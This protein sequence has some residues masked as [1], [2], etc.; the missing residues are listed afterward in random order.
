MGDR[1]ETQIRRTNALLTVLAVV[2]AGFMLLA[3]RAVLLPLAIA[4]FLSYL[5]MPVM[6]AGRKARLPV[7]VL[8]LMVILMFGLGIGAVGLIFYTSTD[9]FIQRLPEYEDRLIEIGNRI[10]KL[11]EL[12][13]YVEKVEQGETAEERQARMVREAES[14]GEEAPPPPVD[15]EG[16]EAPPQESEPES[17][18]LERYISWKKVLQSGGLVNVAGEV[19]GG[20]GNALLVLVFLIFILMDRGRGTL[21]GRITQAFSREGTD[22]ARAPLM[23]IHGEI[24]KYIVTKTLLSLLTGG[25]VAF[26]LALLDIPFALLF[27]L[28][29][30]TLNYIPNVG[31]IIASV[32]PLL[33]AGVHFESVG[34]VVQ[35]GLLLLMI[36]GSIGVL[37]PL[38]T[39]K[40]L[41]LNPTTVLLSLVVWGWLWGA[42]GMVLA[43][44]IAA[45]F[46][47]ISE[48]TGFMRSVGTLMSDRS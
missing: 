21:D 43:V 31:C 36:H 29:A 6:R 4:F 15:Q 39:R 44:P 18:R 25:L 33:V 23:E 24:E 11:P 22:S 13:Q 9:Q 34:A 17:P 5:G 38:I 46:R 1:R 12:E 41:H 37:D 30:F 16:E 19:V 48:H 28:L 47:I 20:F 14:R 45:V 3:L 8:V 2:A 40:P 42:W 26:V 32:P 10:L 27:G 35:T 7:P